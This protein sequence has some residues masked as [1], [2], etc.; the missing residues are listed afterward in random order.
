M[1]ATEQGSLH[2]GA[3]FR[4]GVRLGASFQL[5]AEAQGALG[6]ALAAEVAAGVSAKAAVSLDV[7]FPLD[8]FDEAGIVAR[9]RAQAEAAAY[10]RVRVALSASELASLTEQ[11]LP[12]AVRPMH[13][14]SRPTPRRAR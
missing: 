6:S 14:R 12:P 8:L 2:A 7:G 13:P 10:L 5:A 4:R 1:P 3:E 9:F 11:L